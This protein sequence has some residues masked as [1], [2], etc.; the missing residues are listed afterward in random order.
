MK[1]EM[2]VKRAEIANISWILCLNAR[3]THK[4]NYTCSYALK[5]IL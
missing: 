1:F 4:S 3:I 2:C 5:M